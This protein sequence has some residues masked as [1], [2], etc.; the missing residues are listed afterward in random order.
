MNK[1]KFLK[2]KAI[3]Q[4]ANLEGHRNDLNSRRGLFDP[5]V[6]GGDAVK[7]YTAKV[8]RKFEGGHTLGQVSHYLFTKK[9]YK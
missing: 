8:G 7:D 3:A 2:S 6:T 5:P 4:H 9:K 1:F